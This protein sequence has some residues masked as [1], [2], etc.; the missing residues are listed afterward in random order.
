ME[1]A[2]GRISLSKGFMAAIGRESEEPL[3]MSDEDWD[4]LDRKALGS[5]CLCLAPSVAFNISTKKT[6][7][8]LTSNMAKLYEKPSASNKVFLMKHLFNLKMIEGVS[9]VD[10]LNE[11]NTISS[12]FISLDIKFDEEVRAL[13]IL[14]SFPE[15]WNSLVMVVSNYIS[16]SNT[17]NFD[18]VIGV[19]LGDEIHRKSSSNT[20]TLGSVYVK[21]ELD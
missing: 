7:K 11:F 14:C 6:T 19:I 2:D 13:L 9:L 12:Q 15:R 1:D 5:I 8:D 10:H 18:D 16:S 3:A 21:V 17:L 4:I 20:S